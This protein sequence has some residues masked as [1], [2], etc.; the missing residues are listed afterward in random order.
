M[1]LELY[2]TFDGIVIKL[3]I[4]NQLLLSLSKQLL[5]TLLSERHI[6][7]TYVYEPKCSL[8]SIFK[9]IEIETFLSGNAGFGN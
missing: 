5:S 8:D 6:H 3:D 1:I 2:K 9:M 7:L 4:T